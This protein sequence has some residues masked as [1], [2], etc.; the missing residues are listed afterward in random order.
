MGASHILDVFKWIGFRVAE[1]LLDESR[2][3]QGVWVCLGIHG[4]DNRPFESVA[5]D[6]G[7]SLEF[8]PDVLFCTTEREDEA[9]ESLTPLRNGHPKLTVIT[10]DILKVPFVQLSFEVS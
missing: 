10:V 6:F 1:E 4:Q 9:N 2:D 8:F 3:A 5:R 7:S